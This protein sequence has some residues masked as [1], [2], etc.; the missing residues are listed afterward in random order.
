[1]PSSPSIPR[2]IRGADGAPELDGLLLRQVAE[3]LDLEL[4]VLVLID[5]ERVDHARNGVGLTEALQLLDD[6]AVEVGMVE[7]EDDQL[8]WSRLP[9]HFLFAGI[10]DVSAEPG[11]GSARAHHSIR[12]NPATAASG[13]GG[14]RQ[15]SLN[16]ACCDPS[17]ASQMPH[18]ILIEL[19]VALEGE[20]VARP[21]VRTGRVDVR[22]PPSPAPGSPAVRGVR[23]AS[24][25]GSCPQR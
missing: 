22:P 16:H 18:S 15:G 6:L 5:H 11:R 12:V 17:R 7:T 4:A 10:G 19:L 8:N 2:P 23:R 9:C 24:R 1:M 13:T 14:C 25:A 21:G 20:P 3:V